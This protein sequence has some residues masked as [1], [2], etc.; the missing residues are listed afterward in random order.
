MYG[1][2][3]KTTHAGLDQHRGAYV[4]RVD[5]NDLV[6]LAWSR[7]R[8]SAELLMQLADAWVVVWEHTQRAFLTK[9]VS[10]GSPSDVT[11]SDQRKYLKKAKAL[12]EEIDESAEG[13]D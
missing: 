9:R 2:L 13:L 1:Q 4:A 3:S 5:A 11:P 7:R 8:E 6:M 12:V 10:Y